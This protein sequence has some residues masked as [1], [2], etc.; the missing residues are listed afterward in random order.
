MT[1]KQVKQIVEMRKGGKTN[2]EIAAAFGVSLRTV[3]YWV[4]RLK[5]A[6]YE[7]PRVNRGGRKPMQL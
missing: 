7:L 4:A 3:E 6:G 2:P 1:E 5:K